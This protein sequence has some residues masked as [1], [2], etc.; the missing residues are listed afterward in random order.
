MLQKAKAQCLTIAIAFILLCLPAISH[1][2]TATE[3]DDRRFWDVWNAYIVE[4]VEQELSTPDPWE[5]LN[6]KIF[7][8]NDFADRYALTP[9][10]KGYQWITPDPVE[11]GIGNMFSNLLEV[12]TILNDLLQLKFGQAASDTGRF[13]LNS[14]VGLLGL[15]DV[16]TPIGLEKHEEDFGQTLGYWGVGPGPYIV[17]PIF[18]SYTVRDGLGAYIDTY[19]DYV[20][21]IDHIPTRNQLWLM[22]NID[23]RAGLFAAEELI[24]GDRYAFIRDAYLQRREYLVNDGVVVDSFGEEDWD[25]DWDEESWDE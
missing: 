14:T 11:A 10:A 8:F 7:A 15:F 1:A 19:S 2:Q 20:T 9:V 25:D 16:A 5:P 17:V 4:L 24:T 12:T 18:G 22:R 6:R 23:K 3:E 21:N 13:L